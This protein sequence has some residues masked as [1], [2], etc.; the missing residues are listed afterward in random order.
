MAATS[1]PCAGWPIA[2]GRCGAGSRCRKDTV[3]G[4][5]SSTALDNRREIRINDRLVLEADTAFREH[6][7]DVADALAEGDNVIAV[8]IPLGDGRG[9]CAA[10]GP[11]VPGPL[12]RRQLPDPERQHAAQASVRLRLGLEHR[13]GP[14]RIT[15]DRPRRAGGRGLGRS[16]SGRSTATAPCGS[17]SRPVCARIDGRGRLVGGDRRPG[18][19][20]TR[21]FVSAELVLDDPACGGRTAWA[22]SRSMPSPSGSE[23]PEWAPGTSP[24]A[25]S[26]SSPSRTRWGGVSGS[27]STAATS[28][29]AGPTGF[30][31]DALPGRNHRGR[32]R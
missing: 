32:D 31:A 17:A 23:T 8:T 16:P 30:P 5:S 7:V 22:S 11:A 25:R 20:R 1:T 15:G 28:S 26:A 19:E 12:S 10:G 24:C 6:A 2:T 27:A 13:A 3:A 14:R 9:E 29:P 4:C 18:G 21:R